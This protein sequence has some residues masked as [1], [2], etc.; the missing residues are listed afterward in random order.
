MAIQNRRGV[1][2]RFDPTR[3]LPGE[4]AVVLSDDP[5]AR[6]GR[7]VYVCFAA[8]IVKRMATFE[9][10][11]DNVMQVDDEIIKELLSGLEVQRQQYGE[12][13]KARTSEWSKLSVAANKAIDSA[14]AAAKTATS[15]ASDANDAALKANNAASRAD[16]S[17]AEA[18]DAAEEALS[19]AALARDNAAI[20]NEKAVDA[21]TAA[22]NADT[23]ATAANTSASSADKAAGRA[24][25]AADE[26]A[27]YMKSVTVSWDNLDADCKN[28]IAESASSGLVMATESD[29]KLGWEQIV[30]PSIYDTRGT[31]S[32][33][34][35]EW[36]VDYIVANS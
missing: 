35:L 4:W 23:A 25:S 22:T 12:A 5:N 9:D 10:M 6:D 3:L 17:A 20:A 28:R 27:E 31:L 26:I 18:D 19:A 30:E 8:G 33:S 7:A 24:N 13:E 14:D 34:E 16:T 29:L 32:K 1:F 21:N 15:K 2:T 36:C 11:I